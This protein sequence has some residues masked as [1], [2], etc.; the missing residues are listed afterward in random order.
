MRVQAAAD[1]AEARSENKAAAGEL[2]ALHRELG[3]ARSTQ[4]AE[5]AQLR[6]D[7]EAAAARLAVVEREAAAAAGEAEALRAD[8]ADLAAA[9]Q[10]LQSDLEAEHKLNEEMHDIL[11]S[12]RRQHSRGD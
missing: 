11:A 1:V 9:V 10:Q 12:F 5:A 7:A 4:H 3:E 6:R 2:L 8:K